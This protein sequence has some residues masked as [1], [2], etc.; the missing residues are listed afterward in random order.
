MPDRGQPCLTPGSRL[1]N[2]RHNHCYVAMECLYPI[3]KVTAKIKFVKN[4]K[5]PYQSR[6]KQRGREGFFAPTF[7]P[8]YRPLI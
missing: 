6:G 3:F 7:S 8:I 2:Q 4:L 1:K 5:M